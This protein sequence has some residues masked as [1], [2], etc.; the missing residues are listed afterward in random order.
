MALIE[1]T[2]CRIE[3]INNQGLAISRTKLGEVRLP[4]C[5]PGE[6]VEFERH[7]YR[8]AENFIL[9]AIIEP[10]EE[11]TTPACKYFGA[12]GGCSLQHL[13][14]NY[15][16]KFKS[17]LIYEALMRAGI[18]TKINSIII[19]PPG[20]RRR[21]NFEAIKK[22]DQIYLG[23][24]RFQSH[25]II[26]I[27]QCPILSP[28]ISN[29]IPILKEF[30]FR[31]LS[32]QQKA[33]IYLTQASNGIDILIKSKNEI[34]L[35]E[36]SKFLLSQLTKYD[37]IIRIITRYNEKNNFLL[38]LEK[39]FIVFDGVRVEVDAECFLQA[40]A[41]SDKVLSELVIQ[42][43]PKADNNLKVLDLFC[44]R[45]TFTIPLS[46][47]AKVD[48]FESD[49]Q[50]LKALNK[51]ISESGRDIKLEERDLFNNPVSEK[52]LSKYDHCIINPPRAG[53]K[54]Q[55]EHLGKS[56]IKQIIYVSCNPETFARDAKIL[57]KGGYKL[58]EVTPVD[59]FYWSSHLEVVGVFSKP[60]R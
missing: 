12:C 37:N 51:V 5:L 31:I 1:Q 25:Q 4:Y 58:T 2:K 43:L 60:N 42:Y 32:P 11:R 14:E 48:G 30:L 20:E 53:A 19:I 38:A 26:N 9:K 13:N 28:A 52:Q 55:C 45:G 7:R 21:A 34:F 39:P 47:Y 16:K 50:A 59:Q 3:Y 22:N 18:D 33:E 54:A 35:N 49:K 8:R 10:S 6:L 29:I 46:K 57:L 27:D 24:K 44:G 15:Y 36:D 23:F 41:L 56:Q 40:S 17:N